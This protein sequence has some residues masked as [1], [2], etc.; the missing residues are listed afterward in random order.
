M[1]VDTL[2]SLDEALAIRYAEDLV[3]GG[4][5]AAGEPVKASEAA[6]LAGDD[7]IDLKLARVVL[8]SN[9]K[10]FAATERKW[11]VWTRFA[12]PDRATERNLEETLESYGLPAHADALARELAAIYDR[13]T[14][15]YEVMLERT[16][17][18]QDR[19]FAVGDGRF[20][21]TSWL[22]NASSDN[23][24]DVLFDNYLTEADIARYE[25]DAGK[26]TGA[27]IDAIIKFLDKA[28]EPVPNKA[29][30]FFVWRSN[31]FR[32]NA[33]GLFNAMLKDGRAAYISSGVWVGPRALEKLRKYFKAV[34][35]REVDEYGEQKAAEAQMPLV[36][37][38]E[39]REQLAQKV[40]KGSGAGRAG[41]LLEEIFEV[42]PGE[43]TWDKDLAT[44]IDSLK[45]DERVVWVGA[46]RFVPKGAIP[47]YVFTVPELLHFNTGHYTDAEG[48]DVDLVLEDDGFDGGLQREIH[49][50]LA[51]D[52]LD[53][54]PVYEPEPNPPVTSRCVLKF[55]HKEIGTLPLCQFAPGF[56]PVETPVIQAE[57]VL[58]SGHIA[59][60]WVNSE[61]RL[62]YGLLDWYQTLPV[63]SGAVFYLERHSPDRFLL[64]Y[65]EETEPAMFISRNRVNE[66]M[67]LGQ[68][69]EN[70]ELPTFDILREIMEHY[71]KGIDYLTLLTEV[72]IARRTQRRLVASL[73]SGFHCFFQRGGAWVYDAKKLSQGFDRSKRKYLKK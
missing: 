48:N 56:F 69:A 8:A 45:R 43:P 12:G 19:Y 60:V 25:G 50:A 71:R 24:E 7:N 72:N 11:T 52:V 34:S 4:L 22:L 23:E 57:I 73:L 44:V 18:N 35:E 3:H 40:L 65:G 31:P 36:V 33:A 10:R 61:T 21:L 55:H 6:K 70:E 1:A 9:P 64:T 2:P 20:G 37:T 16:L 62:V 17:S 30:Q 58:P 27:D 66:L 49:S 28:N 15:V 54:E 14:E 47:E 26:L 29:L 68:R 42:T 51:Q 5:L 63:D 39:D 32:F 38:D 41:L 13:P 59:E 53:E 67:E 46:D